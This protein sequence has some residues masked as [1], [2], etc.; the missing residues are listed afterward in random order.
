M[1]RT[2]ALFGLLA[3]GGDGG[4][5]TQPVE[6][7]GP[8]VTTIVITAPIGALQIGATFALSAEVRD[9]RGAA[10]SDKTVA[11]SS[12][13]SDVA[14]V[15][16]AGVL[17][18]VGPGTAAVSASVD[19]K[20]SSVNVTVAQA[21]VFAVTIIPFAVPVVA[22]Q[23]STLVVV[24]TDRNGNALTGRR[25]TYI[26]SAPLVATVDASGRLSALSPGVTTITAVSEGVS[27]SLPITVTPAEGS[28][29]PTI[30]AID[31][32]T[33]SP[34]AAA[35]IR[36]TGFLSA[37]ST[38]VT[39]AG[40]PAAVLSTTPTELTI[41][42]PANGL[43]CQSTQP[44]PLTIATVGGAATASHPLAVARAR[45]LAVGESFVT[46]AAGDIGCNE[47][48]AGGSY[49]V[50]VFNG[51]PTVS[52]TVRFEL[53][54]SAGG[55]ATDRTPS[56]EA[57]LLD[58]APARSIARHEASPA[59][60]A[61]LD[62]LDG[63][64]AILRRLGAPRR[65]ALAPSLSRAGAP[66]V[67][68]TVGVTVP[69]KFHYSSC[70]AAGVTP[71]TARVVWVGARSV[72]LEDVA[73]PLAGRID[74]D[75][76]ALAEEFEKVSF[77][78]LLNFGNPLA[79]DASTDV[80]DRILMLFTPRVNAIN[81]NVLG[82]VSACD[83]YPVSQDASVAGSNEAEIFYARTVTDSTMDPE[84]LNGR[85][86]WRRQMPATMIHE[87]KHIASYAE[88]MARG[89]SQFEHVWL[90]EATAQLAS[91]M[92]GRAI[93][94]NTWRGD[95]T[96]RETLYCESRPTTAGCADGVIAMTNHFSFLSNYLQNFESKSI[97]SGAEDSDIYGSA[98]LFARWLVD[99]Y[100]GSDEGAF[101]RKLVQ[102]GS[103]SGTANVEAA[104]GRP[105]PELLA[106]FTLMLAADNLTN[107]RAPFLEPSWNL[108]DMF[109]GYAEVGSRPPAPLTMRK[110]T[111]G[112]ASIS[113]RN[114]KGGGAVL[115][116]LEPAGAG[117]TQILELKSTPT[118][119]L[120]ATSSV[121]LGV[122]R[123]E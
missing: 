27:G 42:V 17:T 100:G 41:A 104:S 73:G 34:G 74:A 105:F 97:L 56:A 117:R 33:L 5:S 59:E 71:I 21:P 108:P 82:F 76:V 90:E 70:T 61:H 26:S 4:P 83:L 72:V 35:T 116:R 37:A 51:S 11:W 7:T 29:A 101:L 57:P 49:L 110:S 16:S 112:V 44:V 3:C 98:W 77:P 122:V 58:A 47:L 2:A 109:A 53:R 80:N 123:I 89:A 68:L 50:S 36:G 67:P 39:I 64:L 55:A 111:G 14:T 75:L 31:P 92:F 22:G 106:E 6:P 91:E 87:A 13:N 114:V 40:V 88:R 115:L 48:P 28:V 96:Y 25:L 103:L 24:V 113:G 10:M 45:M 62:R 23:A 95:A 43:P 66:P 121:G 15:S 65:R 9:Q 32:A 30:A 54:G 46:G 63:D 119:P 107:A 94:G 81:G 85:S 18:G 69:M 84:T 79:R 8:V 99:T 60:Q 1:W 20:T 12:S 120:T 93:R 118:A 19:G 52:A 86:Q 38:A 78:I 102:S